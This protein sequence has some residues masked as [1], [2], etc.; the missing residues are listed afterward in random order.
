MNIGISNNDDWG[1]ENQFQS[2]E[3]TAEKRSASARGTLFA[4]EA[5][6]FENG[7]GYLRSTTMQRLQEPVMS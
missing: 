5:W 1:I 6:Y 4:S 2:E 3:A 7:A